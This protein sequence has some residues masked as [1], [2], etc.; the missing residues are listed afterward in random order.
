MFQGVG[1]VVVQECT[2]E[3]AGVMT[4]GAATAMPHALVARLSGYVELD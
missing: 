3:T 4:A 1:H 2:E